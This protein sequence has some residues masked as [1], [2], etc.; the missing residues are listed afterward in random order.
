MLYIF[1]TQYSEI[2]IITILQSLY[3]RLKYLPIVIL[4]TCVLC[5]NKHNPN[6]TMLYLKISS[7]LAILCCLRH[8]KK[9]KLSG[10]MFLTLLSIGLF[11]KSF[12]EENQ[13]FITHA[14]TGIMLSN[15][16]L[17]K[18][19]NTVYNVA[20]MIALLFFT[21]FIPFSASITHLFA[22]SNNFF[23]TTCFI[24]PMFL[25]Q[26][27]LKDFNQ[28]NSITVIA[29]GGLISLY[30][31]LCLVCDNKIKHLCIYIITYFYGLNIIST[32]AN[33]QSL[34][35]PLS[36]LWLTLCA[37]VLSCTHISTPK[38]TT[39]YCVYNLKSFAWQTNTQKLILILFFTILTSMLCLHGIISRDVIAGQYWL[40]FVLLLWVGFIAKICY[41][42]FFYRQI[43]VVNPQTPSVK[44]TDFIKTIITFISAIILTIYIAK[45]TSTALIPSM[46]HFIINICWIVGMFVTTYILSKLLIPRQK[47][48]PL[49]S[50]SYFKL[51]LKLIDMVK[52]VID[53]T[54]VSI[55]AFVSTIKN[56]A[57]IILSSSEPTKLTN[58][59]HNNIVYFYIFFLIQTIIVLAIECVIT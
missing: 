47:Q 54:C 37:T 31:G 44:Q 35:L 36:T 22:L 32:A 19:I 26:S 1:L 12:L 18:N 3:M 10:I 11:I 52:M 39:M 7:I 55:Q 15:N 27:V 9:L 40:N 53:I 2:L 30:S 43:N 42:L 58:L 57:Q 34:A 5:L 17:I 41:I 23:K 4:T 20:N 46:K 50:I 6:E 29:F 21:G 13:D 33:Q 8:N 38:R 14:V 56:N 25:V 48:K 49:R 59:L 16:T 24:V 45:H 51:I 28:E